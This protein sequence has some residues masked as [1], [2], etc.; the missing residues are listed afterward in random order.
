M[1]KIF[2]TFVLRQR[3]CLRI[4]L[5]FQNNYYI[6]L[7]LKSKKP[8]FKVN[9]RVRISKY[10]YHFDKGYVGYWTSEVFRVK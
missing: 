8:K 10:K 6:E 7:N 4:Q 3:F 9:D 5:K 2:T 1:S